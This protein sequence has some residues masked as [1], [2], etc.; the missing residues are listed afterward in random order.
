[1]SLATYEHDS[2]SP[3][4]P[5]RLP[6]RGWTKHASRRN[7]QFLYSV[8]IADVPGNGFSFTLTIGD[9]FDECPT[10]VVFHGWIN[11]LFVE[12]RRTGRMHCYHW[13]IEWQKRGVPHIHG[14]V[15][16]EPGADG[17]SLMKTVIDVWL[18][19]SSGTGAR[20]IGQK[21]I[22]LNSTLIWLKPPLS[23]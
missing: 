22:G 10:P 14:V 9:D 1:M 17:E 21:A 5:E 2:N 15:F 3:K 7:N 4:P 19:Y 23:S 20:R 18:K 11:R 13:V 8:R 12:L 6:N 16:E